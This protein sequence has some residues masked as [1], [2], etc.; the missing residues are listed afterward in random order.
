MSQE[1]RPA[2]LVALVVRWAM[3][4]RRKRV[5]VR[6]EVVNLLVALAERHNARERCSR[7][8]NHALAWDTGLGSKDTIRKWILTARDLGAISYRAGKGRGMLPKSDS[9]RTC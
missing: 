7:P 1:P 8:G 5:H 4:Q 2:P 9:P 3:L 6:G